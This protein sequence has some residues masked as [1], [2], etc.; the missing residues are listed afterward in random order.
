MHVQRAVQ[1]FPLQ[2]GTHF[3]GQGGCSVVLGH[4]GHNW[5]K[6]QETAKWHVPIFFRV[7]IK[8]DLGH[9]V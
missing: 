3:F 5:S 9:I 6:T 7:P 4:C 8:S 2:I 1:T